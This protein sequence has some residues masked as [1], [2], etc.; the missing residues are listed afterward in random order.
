MA[1]QLETGSIKRYRGLS[2]DV[3][4]GRRSETDTEAVQLPPIGSIFTESDTGARYVW[5]GPWQWLRQE[6]T[7]E[8]LLERLIDVNS[9]VL[10]EL[11]AIRRGHEE[12]SWGEEVEPE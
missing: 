5:T 6:Q 3:K 12:Y 10:S 2:T 8:G 11:S 7:V 9:H 1:I 4:P